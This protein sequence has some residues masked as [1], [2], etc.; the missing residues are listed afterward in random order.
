LATQ[1]IMILQHVIP[2]LLVLRKKYKV[3]DP[4]LLIIGIFPSALL[5]QW[6]WKWI[7]V[8]DCAKYSPCSQYQ[9]FWLQVDMVG[10]QPC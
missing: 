2:S 3:S 10:I 1:T 8:N 5:S 6:Q 7:S 9:K 4:E